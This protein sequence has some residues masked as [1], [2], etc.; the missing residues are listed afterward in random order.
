M[1][2]DS[3][4]INIVEQAHIPKF[5]KLGD[6]GIPLRLFELF[7][8]DALVDMIIGCTKLNGDREKANTSVEITNAMFQ[9]PQVCYC[10]VGFIRF[11]TITCTGRHSSVL[12][13]KQ[14]GFQRGQLPP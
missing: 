3:R 13:Y 4:D 1:K 9:S 6:K 10:L 14:H 11:Q 8:G 7:F 12:L 2:Q 5:R